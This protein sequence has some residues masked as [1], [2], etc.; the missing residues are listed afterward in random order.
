MKFSQWSCFFS[1]SM[2]FADGYVERT[3]APGGI[4][5]NKLPHRTVSMPY[6]NFHNAYS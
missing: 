6:L 5:F 4:Q 3:Y 2:L 1:S